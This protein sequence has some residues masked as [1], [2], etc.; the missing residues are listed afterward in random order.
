MFSIQ[1]SFRSFAGLALA[2]TVFSVFAPKDLE[3]QANRPLVLDKPRYTLTMPANGWDSVAVPEGQGGGIEFSLLTKVGGFGGLAYVGCEPGT[4][5]PNL[6]EL[7]ANFAGVLGG[8]ITRGKDSSLTLGPYSVKWQEFKY[9]SLPLLADMV[10]ERAGFRPDLRNGSF[11]VYYLNAQG[12]VFTMA[13]IKILPMGVP[14]YADIETAIATLRLK[15]QAGAVREAARDLGGGLW[16]RGGLLGG[17]WLKDHPAASVDCFSPA[18]A[19]IGSGRPDGDGAFILP[20]SRSA[21][22]IVVRAR[23]GK[24]LSVIAQP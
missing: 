14:P 7:A 17:S 15:P 22:V 20:A 13:G 8:N 5:P 21:L 24:S 10:E 12:Y 2:F 4:L 16:T 1:S 18:G 9:D 11:R 6:D 19:Y 3:A 23:N